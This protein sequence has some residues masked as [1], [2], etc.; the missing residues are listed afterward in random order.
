[1]PGLMIEECLRTVVVSVPEMPKTE[2][3]ETPRAS[4]ECMRN[5]AL[6]RNLQ[7]LLP[8][9]ES[10]AR[11][12]SFTLAG[13]EIGLSQS[14]VSKQI[15]ELESR[16]GQRLFI[17]LHKRIALTP[18]GDRLFKTYSTATL[19]VID[20]VEDLIHERSREQIVL[21]TT[22]GIG[23]FMLLPRLAEIR[24]CFLGEQIFLMTW[25]P[26]G[27]EPAGQ[28]DLALIYGDPDV[29]GIAT[30]PLFTDVVTP[31]CTPEFLAKNGPLGEVRDLLNCELLYTQ[32]V[33]S[34]INWRQWLREFDVELPNNYQTMGFNSDYSTIQACLAGEGVALGWLRGLSNMMELGRLVTPLSQYLP[35]EDR[36]QLAWPADKPPEF[37]IEPF[38]DW[39]VRRYG[40]VLPFYPPTN[41]A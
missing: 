38:Y 37:S 13:E 1:M 34:W 35:T 27:I 2:M 12:K 24:Q 7:R 28:F 30:R 39:L 25:D 20:V 19:Q 40:G 32:E 4:Q 23:A 18:A 31:V 10:A 15:I 8:A 6:F 11:L 3:A 16:L 5:K 17:R 21:S 33:P 26:R 41:I 14:S 9:F 29:R 36:Y 22:T